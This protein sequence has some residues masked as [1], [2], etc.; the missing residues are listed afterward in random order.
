MTTPPATASYTD[1]DFYRSSHPI[2]RFVT[3]LAVIAAVLALTWWAAPFNTRLSFEVAST[4]FDL[5]E[6]HG[7]LE[8]AITN[9]APTPVRI[10]G[11]HVDLVIMPPG[12]VTLDGVPLASTPELAGNSTGMLTIHYEGRDCPLERQPG[13]VMMTVEAETVAGV[14]KTTRTSLFNEGGSAGSAPC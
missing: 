3:A 13:G 4:A 5:A 6:R 14:S 12:S 8:I 10:A 2:R 11:A 9:E 1:E 7:T